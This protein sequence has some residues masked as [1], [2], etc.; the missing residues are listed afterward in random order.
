MEPNISTTKNRPELRQ[1]DSEQ[2]EQPQ[3]LE[4][5]GDV[6]ISAFILK[7]KV[8]VRPSAFDRRFLQPWPTGCA[9]TAH[10]PQFLLYNGVCYKCRSRGE[11]EHPQGRSSWRTSVTAQERDVPVGAPLQVTEK[12]RSLRMVGTSD[13]ARR[14]LTRQLYPIWCR[15]LQCG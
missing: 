1:R 9:C 10:A 5:S 13:E 14:L 12:A 4:S 2:I 8:K 6:M 15:T 11:E 7:E 3:L